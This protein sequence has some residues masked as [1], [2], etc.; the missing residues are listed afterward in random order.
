MKVK[1][2][3]KLRKMARK[4]VKFKLDKI[5]YIRDSYNINSYVGRFYYIYYDESNYPCRPPYLQDTC[6]NVYSE[7]E[8]KKS[9]QKLIEKSVYCMMRWL[10]FKKKKRIFESS[11]KKINEMF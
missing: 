1:L 11:Q 4:C 9:K 6:L 7:N 5:N 8:L 2:L 10:K 3:K